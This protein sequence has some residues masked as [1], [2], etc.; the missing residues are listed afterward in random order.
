MRIGERAIWQLFFQDIAV[1]M[2][3]EIIA[4]GPN[5]AAAFAAER[6][7][8]GFELLVG[9]DPVSV[10]FV[11]NAVEIVLADVDRKIIA[12]IVSVSYTHLTLPTIY[13]V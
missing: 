3:W 2:G 6:I 13:S 9:R 8:A 10:L 4:R 11:A 1:V 12:P 7:A 5:L